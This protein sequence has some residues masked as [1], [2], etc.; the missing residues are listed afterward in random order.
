MGAKQLIG[1]I[2]EVKT[3]EPDPTGETEPDPWEAV[4]H[5]VGELGDRLKQTYRRVADETGPTEDE[6]RQAFATLAGVWEQ[7]SSSLSGVLEDPE[8]RRRLKGT[9]ASLADALGETIGEVGKEIKGDAEE[10]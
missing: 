6:I 9:A 1:T 4:H 10:E 5:Q 8:V 2:E 3:H 7:I